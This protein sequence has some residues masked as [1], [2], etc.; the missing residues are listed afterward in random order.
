MRTLRDHRNLF[1]LGTDDIVCSLPCFHL[2]ENS[3][4]EL[5]FFPSRGGVVGNEEE[6]PGGRESSAGTGAFKVQ[7]LTAKLPVQQ[8]VRGCHTSRGVD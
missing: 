8:G 4:P 3:F 5:D 1:S 6:S 7:A 2:K